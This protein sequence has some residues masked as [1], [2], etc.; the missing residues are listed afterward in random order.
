MTARPWIS[1]RDY[2]GKA[3]AYLRFNWA[4][5]APGCNIPLIGRVFT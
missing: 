1:G 4:F 5:Q 3:K 2:T